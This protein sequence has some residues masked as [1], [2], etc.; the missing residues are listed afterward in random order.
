[1]FNP[2]APFLIDG[3]QVPWATLLSL[4]WTDPQTGE[5]SSM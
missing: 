4:N 1:M 5:T 3:D 2:L